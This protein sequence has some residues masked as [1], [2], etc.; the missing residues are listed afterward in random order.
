MNAV[1]TPAQLV[2]ANVEREQSP[3]RKRGFQ[4]LFH[5]K[6]EAPTGL[7]T[8]E[9]LELESRLS[10]EVSDSP[11]PR[12]LSYRNRAGRFVLVRFERLSEVDKFQRSGRYFAH[13]LLFSPADFASIENDPFRVF[14]MPASPFF[15][16]L[17]Q[18]RAVGDFRDGAIEPARVVPSWP[19]SDFSWADPLGLGPTRDLVMTGLRAADLFASRRT[20]A[21]AGGPAEVMGILRG[22][23]RALPPMARAACSFDTWAAEKVADRHGYWAVGLREPVPKRPTLLAFSIAK[24]GFA[25]PPPVRVETPLEMWVDHAIGRSEE[26][27]KPSERLEGID[28]AQI[29]A[30]VMEW[31]GRTTSF[32][33]APGVANDFIKANRERLERSLSERLRDL[34]GGSPPSWLQKQSQQWTKDQGS[35]VAKIRAVITGP[36]VEEIAHWI[37]F[38]LQGDPRST[39]GVPLDR[40]LRNCLGL[41]SATRDYLEMAA[42]GMS[43]DWE[44]LQEVFAEQ[45]GVLDPNDW[46]W[47]PDLILG[48]F[49]VSCELCAYPRG[50]CVAFGVR[51]RGE[52]V[53]ASRFAEAA[54]ALLAAEGPSCRS[55]LDRSAMSSEEARTALFTVDASHWAKWQMQIRETMVHARSFGCGWLFQPVSDG[56]FFGFG[57]EVDPAKVGGMEIFLDDFKAPPEVCSRVPSSVGAHASV[58]SRSSFRLVN[59]ERPEVYLAVLKSMYRT[60]LAP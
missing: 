4:T 17:D 32:E 22:L 18:A 57:Y 35:T 41:D 6:G 27:A 38:R 58:R 10:H 59:P 51:T 47:I 39:I 24:P 9:V 36:S 43:R 34:V 23:I 2:F 48:S 20:V 16:D 37:E 3:H 13:A 55:A 14:D 50:G 8:A 26:G 19:F 56:L 49:D 12:Y 53:S 60:T 25:S 42:L 46:E 30:E 45:V 40:L 31:P 21:L 52:G 15:V 44:R 11:V 7:T 5:T 54:K 29:L 33:V 28:D 1:L